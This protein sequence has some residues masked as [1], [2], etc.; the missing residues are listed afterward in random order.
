MESSVDRGAL[1][2]IAY[3]LVEVQHDPGVLLQIAQHITGER[4]KI[5][6]GTDRHPCRRNCF[7]WV[8]PLHNQRYPVC[9]L[10]AI[11]RILHCL[12]ISPHTTLVR[13]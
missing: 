3:F 10:R 6:I 5:D 11:L 7:A 12:C 4:P 8:A 9:N 13:E 1:V 2:E